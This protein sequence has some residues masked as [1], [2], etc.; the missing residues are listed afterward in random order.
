MK[1]E[2]SNMKIK[3]TGR[4]YL[5]LTKHIDSNINKENYVGL[6]TLLHDCHFFKYLDYYEQEIN[7][8]INFKRSLSKF[9][10]NHLNNYFLIRNNLLKNKTLFNNIEIELTGT[11][12][13]ELNEI[14]EWVSFLNQFIVLLNISD[15]MIDFDNEFFNIRRI[16]DDFNTLR[17]HKRAESR[18]RIEKIKKDAFLNDDK[19]INLIEKAMKAK[20]V[21]F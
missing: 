9:Q 7:Y 8:K 12:F 4:E 6:C 1:K 16:V 17:M 15:E 18:K 2:C 21:S 10:V 19:I 5:K 11:E 3:M 13:N 20:D 14:V